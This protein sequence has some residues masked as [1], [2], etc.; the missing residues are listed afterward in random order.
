MSALYDAISSEYLRVSSQ[1]SEFKEYESYLFDESRLNHGNIDEICL[2]E[3]EMHIVEIMKDACRKHMPVT[4]SAGRTGIVGGAVPAEGLLLSLEKMNRIRTV[5]KKNDSW[6]LV[7]EPGVTLAEIESGLQK[8]QI[9]FTSQNESIHHQFHNESKKW[10]YP[11]DPTEKTAHLG[12]T[13]AT[14]ASGAHSLKY[15]PTRLHVNHIRVVLADGTLLQIQRG[16]YVVGKNET[17]VIRTLN[18]E[19]H[20]PVPQYQYPELKNTAGYFTSDPMDLIDYFIGSEGTLGII[21]EIGVKLTK[22]PESVLGCLIFFEIDKN[23]FDF[24]SELKS[25]STDSSTLLKPSVIE[26]F[27]P[28]ALKLIHDKALESLKLSL[29]ENVQ[30]AIYIEQEM[31]EAQMDEIYIEYETL[32]NTFHISLDDAWAA[33]EP[34]E[35]KHM[36]EF[37]HLVPESV[38]MIIGQRQQ[39]LPDLHKISTDFVVPDTQ[40]YNYI[41]QIR[42]ELTNLQIEHV[43]FGHAGESHLHVN[44]IPKS[45]LELQKAKEIYMQFALKVIQMGGSISGEHGIG[46]LKKHLFAKAFSAFAIAEMQQVKSLLDTKNIL[47]KNVLF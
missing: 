38:N 41:K 40:L 44:I 1:Q 2:P 17:F 11:P 37:R 5:Q 15:G 19:I 21:T 12:G 42:T 33:M 46:K 36:A 8:S 25:H 47:N 39:S 31:P 29:P 22:R 9:N 43:V 13:I 30:A 24:I 35:L 10:F 45:E 34:H 32:L 27:G 23:A 18:D 26:Y 14:N 20:L 16:E 3:N 4:I 28:N 7:C 6:V